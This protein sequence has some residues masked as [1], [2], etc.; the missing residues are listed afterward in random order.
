QGDAMPSKPRILIAGAGIAGLATALALGQRGFRVD[1]FEQ[2]SELMELGAGV[3]ISANGSRVL[4][5]LGLG[6]AMRQVVCEATL[7]EVRMW[8]TGRT[9]KLFDLGKDSIERFGAPYWFVHRGDMHRALLDAVRR[10]GGVA[11]RTGQRCSHFAQDGSRVML[12]LAGGE[13]V[14]G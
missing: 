8:N 11:V 12:E 3:Q 1:I 2:A 13:R 6:E 7:K 14:T 5:A 10:T 4:I 9:W